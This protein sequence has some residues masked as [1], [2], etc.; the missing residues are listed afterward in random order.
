LSNTDLEKTHK[1]LR[2]LSAYLKQFN[3]KPLND[4]ASFEVNRAHALGYFKQFKYAHAIKYL[5]PAVSNCPKYR[6]AFVGGL[7]DTLVLLTEC[8]SALG[9]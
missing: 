9:R 4:V 8:Y 5:N 3:S 7:S 2:G 6:D 1:A